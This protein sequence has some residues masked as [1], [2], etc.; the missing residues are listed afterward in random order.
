[1]PTV[2]CGLRSCR[3]VC[4]CLSHGCQ[5]DTF[6][7]YQLYG[8]ACLCCFVFAEKFLFIFRRKIWGICW[9]DNKGSPSCI[10][11][12]YTGRFEAEGCLSYLHVTLRV[13]IPY[14]I[15][16]Q[17]LFK[18]L[19]PSISFP[20]V[21]RNNRLVCFYP[22]SWTLKLVKSMLHSGFVLDVMRM[23]RNCGQACAL[24]LFC[25]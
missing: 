21:L 3:R 2:L 7:K 12:F 17:L 11:P 4:V 20:Y 18:I 19:C 15:I 13:S 5:T 16:E 9:D 10:F 8:A 1:M 23:L 24:G 25:N 22:Y 6:L 14:T